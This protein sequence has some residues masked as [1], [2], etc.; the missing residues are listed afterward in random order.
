MCRI[1]VQAVW[2]SAS[3][4]LAVDA[5]RDFCDIGAYK[6]VLP[7][8][9]ACPASC[10]SMPWSHV[11]QLAGL[12]LTWVPRRYEPVKIHDL[13]RL[14][15]VKAGMKLEDVKVRFEHARLCR[16]LGC[17]GGGR[18]KFTGASIWAYAGTP[19]QQVSAE[20]CHSAQNLCTCRA[21]TRAFCSAHTLCSSRRVRL[22][23]TCAMQWTG[24][25]KAL[26][27]ATSWIFMSAALHRRP[28][29]ASLSLVRAGSS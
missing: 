28:A 24:T 5:T 10:V 14:E 1:N 17:Q 11:Q 20:I 15:K 18:N 23:R 3:A 2:F 26:A 29:R 4:D 9:A 13:K 6:S 25:R 8:V 12:H 27:T 7:C 16:S 21:W 19:A 22:A